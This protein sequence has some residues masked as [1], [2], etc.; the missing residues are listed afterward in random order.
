MAL[1][2]NHFGRIESAW[3]SRSGGLKAELGS[4]DLVTAW[5]QMRGVVNAITE[6]RWYA[7]LI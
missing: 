1:W 3:F 7:N 4:L 5:Q 6:K 2:Q